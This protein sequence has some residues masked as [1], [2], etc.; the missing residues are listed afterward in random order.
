MSIKR[1]KQRTF[2]SDRDDK[3]N[4]DYFA[5][6]KV[7]DKNWQEHTEGKA[8]DAFQPYAFSSRFVM[9]ALLVHSKFGK[10]VVV[11]IDAT[12]VDVLF[13]EGVKKLGHGGS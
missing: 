11:G 7:P 12:N 13:Q 10:G 8:D 3:T 5:K 6:P 2:G 1:A 4:K 9:G